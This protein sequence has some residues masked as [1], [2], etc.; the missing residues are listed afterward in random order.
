MVKVTGKC[1]RG[2]PKVIDPRGSGEIPSKGTMRQQEKAGSLLIQAGCKNDKK[3]K[4]EKWKRRLHGKLG[5]GKCGQ[6]REAGKV[7]KGR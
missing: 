3:S 7:S 4:D 2:S 6:E 1:V 5:H